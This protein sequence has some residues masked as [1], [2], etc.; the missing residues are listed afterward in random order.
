MNCMYFKLIKF[1]MYIV[2]LRHQYLLQGD[3]LYT[4]MDLI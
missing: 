4:I 1:R 3:T 2:L